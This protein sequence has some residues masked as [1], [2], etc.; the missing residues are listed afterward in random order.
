MVI[1]VTYGINLPKLIF[2]VFV[3]DSDNYMENCLGM[4]VLENLMSAT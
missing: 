1:S 2:H 3:C 4:I